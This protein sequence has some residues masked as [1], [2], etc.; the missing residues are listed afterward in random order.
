MVKSRYDSVILTNT[1]VHTDS[2]SNIVQS[3]W[4]QERLLDFKIME[5]ELMVTDLSLIKLAWHAVRDVY[6]LERACL[7]KWT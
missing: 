4:K 1:H 2:T 5:F 7:F 6:F 3:Y